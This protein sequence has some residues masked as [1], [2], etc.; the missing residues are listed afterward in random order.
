MPDA[1]TRSGAFGLHA[2]RRRLE[3]K[4]PDQASLRLESSPEGT[5]SI[6]ELAAALRCEG[7]MT[8]SAA[9]VTPDARR[10]R[11]LVV[12]DEWPTRNY[13]VELIEATGSPRWWARSR[14]SRRRARR[15][16][17]AGLAVDVVFVDVQLAGNDGGSRRARAGSI[18]RRGGSRADVRPR[19]RVRP[20]RARGVRARRRRLPPEAVQR[21]ARRAGAA[22]APRAPPGRVEPAGGHRAS[23]PAGERASCS[24]SRRRSGRSRPPTG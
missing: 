3:L 16:C 18:G 17:D 1:E 8:G 4:F 22:A 5:R 13:L 11:A 7:H 10:L 14:R 15:S 20:A 6:V 9:T 21:G 24:S 2:V 19:D 23:S 12:E